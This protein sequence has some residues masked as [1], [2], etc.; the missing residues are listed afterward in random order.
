VSGVAAN[1]SSTAT[2]TTTQAGYVDGAAQVTATS[3][4]A[5]NTPTF[6]TPTAT[7]DGFTVQISNYDANFTYGGSATAG[8]TVTISNTGVV[9][10]SGVAANTACTATITTTQAGYASGSA[11]VTETSAPAATRPGR[12]T[13]VVATSGNSQLAVTWTAPAITGG[14]A[15]TD[16]LVKYSSNGG[17]T[18]TNFVHPA[19]TVPSITVTGLTNGTAYVI[20]VIAKNAVGISLPS[21]NSA[22]ATPL[23]AALTP[24]F[25]A[26]TRTA[27]GFTVQIGNYNAAYSWTGTATASGSVAISGTGLV[28]V[29]GVALATS[30]TAT[31]TATRT[32]FAR[33]SATVAATSLAAAWAYSTRGGSSSDINYYPKSASEFSNAVLQGYVT[34]NTP[35]TASPSGAGWF[36]KPDWST[37]RGYY[38]YTTYASSS[39]DQTLLVANGGDDGHSVFVDDVFI[40][41]GGFAVR[42]YSSIAFAAGVARKITV[43]GYNASGVSHVSFSITN[44]QRTSAVVL[45]KVPGISMTPLSQAAALTPTFGAK[46]RT[47]TGF[48]VPITNYNAAY[49]WTGT[50]TASGSVAISGTGLVTVTGVAARTKSTATIITSKS[51]TVSGTATVT[52]T[53]LA[54]ALTPTFGATTATA[55]GFTV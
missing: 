4:S 15:I 17:L 35:P 7:A 14:S 23:A 5:A 31:I 55:T 44:A 50:A 21:A 10:V 30:S 43:V 26:K 41:G 38:I 27:T 25:G 37:S 52:A 51:N 12:P 16:Y 42:A 9:T 32:G 28:T 8:G 19:S 11:T 53:S 33:G 6:G 1:T 29:T 39:T 13:S 47:A 46:T 22:P 24:T 48:T 3:L 36:N 45:E 40:A 49:T 2:I 18:W 34:Y 20:K 54:A